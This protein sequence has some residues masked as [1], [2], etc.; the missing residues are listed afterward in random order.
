M[1]ALIRGW[2][3]QGLASE[4]GMSLRDGIDR[5]AA[6]ADHSSG[7]LPPTRLPNPVGAV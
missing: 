3:V 5:L 7:W 1:S 4:Q 6:D 2:V